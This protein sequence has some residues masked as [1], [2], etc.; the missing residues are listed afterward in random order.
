MIYREEN[1]TEFNMRVLIF[2]KALVW[3]I[4]QSRIPRDIVIY[5]C[6]ASF[7]VLVILVRF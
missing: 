4:S 6:R 7:K 2:S 3:N 5:V 1:V